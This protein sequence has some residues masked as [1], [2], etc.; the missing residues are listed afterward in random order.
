MTADSAESRRP[1]DLARLLL[2]SGSAPPR[3]R[4]RDQQADLA[5]IE[6]HRRM[7]DRLAAI[8]PEPEEIERALSIIVVEMGEPSGPSRAVALA[9]LQDWETAL[10]APEFWSWLISEAVAA[11]RD[12]RGRDHVA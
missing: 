3:Q 7:L 5:G 8:D 10:I 6:L 9:V 12:R 4:A 1:A 11:G 2:A